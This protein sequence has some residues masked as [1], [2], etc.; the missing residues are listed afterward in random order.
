MLRDAPKPDW[1]DKKMN[2]VIYIN[3]TYEEEQALYDIDNQK[4]LLKGDYYHDKISAKISGY[5]L[6]KGVDEDE[7]EEVYIDQYH[8]LFDFLKFYDG[9]E[10]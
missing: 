1:R 3:E 10:D 2:L 4:V 6:A 9:S 8:I 5:L 7:V